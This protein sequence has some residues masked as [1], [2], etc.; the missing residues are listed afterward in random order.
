MSATYDIAIIGGGVVGTAIARELS[1]FQLKAVLLEAR[2]DL[3]DESSKGNSALMCSG[4]DVPAGTL[5]RQLVQRG[6]ARYMAEAPEMGLPIRKI[7]A[8]TLAWS[9]EQQGILEQELASARRDGF[10]ADLLESAEIYR[11]WPQFG[12]GIRCGLW[13]PDE[14]IVD[15]FS[16]PHAYALDA[17]ENGVEIRRGW[18]VQCAEHGTQGW[19]LFNGDDRII[20]RCVVNAGGI[21]A[22]HVEALAGYGDFAIRPRRGQYMVL[23][24]S[25]R[26]IHDVIA[27]PTPTPTTRGILI[28]PTIFG[29]VLVGPTAENVEDRDDRRVTD[30][31][32]A[33]LRQAIAT[34]IPALAD[35]PVNTIFAGMRPATQFRDYQIIPRLARGWLTV[36]GIRSTGL[37]ASLGIAEHVAALLVPDMFDVAR[38]PAPKRITVPSLSETSLRPWQDN[39]RITTDP[40][41]AE[42]ICHCERISR[43]EI[44]DALACPLAPQTLNGLKRRTRAMFGRCQGFYCGARVQAMFDEGRGAPT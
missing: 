2:P 21:R 33:Q 29:N 10:T 1:R 27:M 7:G 3:G 40:C 17:L 38:R 43:G 12:A 36:A 23:D 19:T 5:E 31:G 11:R 9:E 20:A 30:E 39:T 8:V 16:T 13:A 37:S 26:A 42:M 14:A 25:A 32:L 15:P 34:M 35:Q 41:Y 4:I 44:R 18:P 24:K 6:Y 28:A 22:D